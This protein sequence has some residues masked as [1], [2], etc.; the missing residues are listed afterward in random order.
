M[1]SEAVYPVTARLNALGGTDSDCVLVGFTTENFE[2]LN[3]YWQAAMGFGTDFKPVIRRRI[4]PK[5]Q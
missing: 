3:L 1:T 5:F 4:S 2:D